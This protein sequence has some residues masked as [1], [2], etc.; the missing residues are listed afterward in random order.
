MDIE[1]LKLTD[2]YTSIQT[3]ATTMLNDLERMSTY[4]FTAMYSV[5]NL[6]QIAAWWSDQL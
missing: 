2:L 1:N 6:Q 3:Q 4:Q 5:I